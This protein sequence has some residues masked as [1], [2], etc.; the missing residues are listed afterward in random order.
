MLPF[1]VVTGI[2][3]EGEPLRN[4]SARWE[5]AVRSG[6]SDTDLV[7]AHSMDGHA[8][9]RESMLDALPLLRQ[10]RFLHYAPLEIPKPS[11]KPERRR[12]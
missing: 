7:D 2:F 1:N 8:G 3:Y 6:L 12:P 5:Q 9:S 4:R 11:Q 10:H